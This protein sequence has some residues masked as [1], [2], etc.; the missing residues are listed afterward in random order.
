MFFL[1]FDVTQKDSFTNIPHWLSFIQNH[2][3][4]KHAVVLIANKTEAPYSQWAVKREDILS[5]AQ[6]KEIHP[7]F[8]VSA[9]DDAHTISTKRHS[10]HQMFDIVVHHIAKSVMSSP[11]QTHINGIHD[12]RLLFIGEQTPE[13][14]TPPDTPPHSP[15]QPQRSHTITSKQVM[16]SL[17]FKQYSTETCPSFSLKKPNSCC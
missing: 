16:T 11:I 14:N 17:G 6:S 10:I 2:C 7:V 15:T 4:G 5:F 13:L 8:F 3:T 9:N 1:V 12:K